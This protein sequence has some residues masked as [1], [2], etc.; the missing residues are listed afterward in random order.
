MSKRANIDGSD[1]PSYTD[2]TPS[3][4]DVPNSLLPTED[5]DESRCHGSELAAERFVGDGGCDSLEGTTKG[6]IGHWAFCQ[7]L[8]GNRKP[9]SN[10]Y[11]NGDGGWDEKFGG[12]TWDLKTVGQHVETPALTVSAMNR[13]RADRYVLINRI[14]K[15]TCRIVGYAPQETV[16]TQQIRL[17]EYDRAYYHVPRNKLIPFPPILSE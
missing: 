14:G 12:H 3:V 2:P 15:N 6:T 1:T 16:K 17:G 11:P 13:L 7:Y 9:D 5:V 8:P 10:V 4:A